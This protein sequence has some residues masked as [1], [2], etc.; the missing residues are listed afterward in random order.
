MQNKLKFEREGK[1][2]I[3]EKLEAILKTKN[4]LIKIAYGKI[5]DELGIGYTPFGVTSVSKNSAIYELVPIAV[6]FKKGS[7]LQMKQ[8]ISVLI[9]KDAKTIT[10]AVATDAAKFENGSKEEIET[11]EFLLKGVKSEI[12]RKGNVIEIELNP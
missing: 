4:T 5:T 6:R 3:Q 1:Q 11:D 12:R 10:F 9:D 7:L 8:V 2:K